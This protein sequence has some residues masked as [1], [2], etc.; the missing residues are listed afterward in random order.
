MFWVEIKSEKN[1]LNSTYG[2]KVFSYYSKS[3]KSNSRISKRKK[4]LCRK[5]K[6]FNITV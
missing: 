6:S 5:G 2:G 3:G 1:Y 4:L